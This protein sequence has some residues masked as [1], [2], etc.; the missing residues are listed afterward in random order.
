MA[1]TKT[2]PKCQ[3]SMTEGFIIDNKESGRAVSSWLE[4][5]PEKSIWTGVKLKGR[6]PLDIA[7]WRCGSC[8]YLESYAGGR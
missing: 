2:C 1:R 4:G 8:A 7:T 3:S 5:T 6:K